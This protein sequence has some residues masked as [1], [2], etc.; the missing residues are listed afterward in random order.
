MIKEIKYK[1]GW[2]KVNFL[3]SDTWIVFRWCCYIFPIVFLIVLS[4]IPLF[5]ALFWIVMGGLWYW[6]FPVLYDRFIRRVE[7]E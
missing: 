7:Y 4:N 5:R 1:L 6:Y 3:D 2:Y